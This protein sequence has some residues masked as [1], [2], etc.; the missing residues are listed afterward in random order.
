MI[1]GKYL[2]SLGEILSIKIF[3][4]IPFSFVKRINKYQVFLQLLAP[5]LGYMLFISDKDRLKIL[6]SE[7]SLLLLLVTINLIP[8][9]ANPSLHYFFRLTQL[10]GIYLLGFCFI[11]RITRENLLGFV[12]LVEL[13]T[14]ILIL[15]QLLFGEPL[16]TREV[17]DFNIIRLGGI[18]GEP[19]YSAALMFGVMAI[20]IY[21]KEYRR[22]LLDL[23]LLITT[24]SR[25]ALVVVFLYALLCFVTVI[26]RKKLVGYFI[27]F[28]L[29]LLLF[30]P[31]LLSPFNQMVDI[32]IRNK[33]NNITASRLII[34]SSYAERARLSFFGAGYFQFDNR[35]VPEMMSKNVRQLYNIWSN[36]E[37]LKE[38]HSMIIQVFTDFGV[39]GHLIFSVFI[40]L[41]DRKAKSVSSIIQL[42]WFCIVMLFSFINGMNEIIIYFWAS[43]II[44]L[45]EINHKIIVEKPVCV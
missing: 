25:T 13:L 30:Y 7:Y 32:D 41:I 17:F 3:I 2:R 15:C 36:K 31:Y 4:L 1:V 28:C 43:F 12:R 10:L 23:A 35:I 22:A 6:K 34:A 26:F 8:F 40:L 45:S 14:I 11:S 29:G 16:W 37:K 42:T 21:Y 24:L 18:I 9:L 19:N 38:Q 39:F 44:Y 5:V 27:T 20:N 33:L